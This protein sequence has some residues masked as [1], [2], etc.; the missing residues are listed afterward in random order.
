[1]PDFTIDPRTTALLNVDVQNCFVE[2]SPVAAKHGP[3]IIPLVNDIAEAVRRNGGLVVHTLHVVRPDG[4]TTGVMGEF[5]AAIK[6]GLLFKGNP[7]AELHKDVVVA[8]ADVIM[9]K[10][11]YGAF[12]G[13]ELDVILKNR[14]IE[15]VIVT[16]ITTN[17]CCETTAREANMRD[18][19]VLFASDATATFDLPEVTAEQIQQSVCATLAMAFA[20]VATAATIVDKLSLQRSAVSV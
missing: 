2:N 5:N 10:P 14:G 13:T 12:Y 16:G 8:P 19:Q 1:M 4:S 20:Q 6:A 18:L 15:T 3:D 9:D 11:R 17:V 7:A